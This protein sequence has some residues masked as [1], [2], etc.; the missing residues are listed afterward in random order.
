MRTGVPVNVKKTRP[1]LVVQE[2]EEVA[3]P[4]A[5]GNV[6]AASGDAAA[7]ENLSAFI[8]D[9][10][11]TAVDALPFYQRSLHRII[12]HAR[13]GGTEFYDDFNEHV[14]QRRNVSLNTTTQ[15][16][17]NWTVDNAKRELV[18]NLLDEVARA[19]SGHSDT[20]TLANIQIAVGSR[21][22][23]QR[24]KENTIVFHND[25]A[26]LAE[27]VYS[28]RT[29]ELRFI[30][31]GARINKG[32]AILFYGATDKVGVPN[33]TGCYGEGLKRAITKFIAVGCQV[34]I[35]GCIPERTEDGRGA[36]KIHTYQTWKF[37]ERDGE[38]LFSISAKNPNQRLVGAAHCDRDRFE[39][40]I[41]FPDERYAGSIDL[42]QF[43]VPRAHLRDF[44]Q[45]DAPGNIIFDE[46]VRR[47]VYVRHFYVY[48][49]K[50]AIFS[51]DFN[52]DISRDRDTLEWSQYCDAVAKCWSHL[53]MT[54]ETR[55]NQFYELLCRKFT[56][57]KVELEG[58]LEMA[59]RKK[60][61]ELW[62]SKNPQCFPV[63][64]WRDE[65]IFFAI[66]TTM[67]TNHMYRNITH[68][69]AAITDDKCARVLFLSA[70]VIV[71]KSKHDLIASQ[72]EL[73]ILAQLGP[74]FPQVHCFMSGVTTED[75]AFAW[76][77]DNKTIILNERTYDFRNNPR[78]ALLAVCAKMSLALPLL[79][80][81]AYDP[82][83]F[84]G[85]F[86]RHAVMQA[87]QQWEAEAPLVP[88]SVP[89]PSPPVP[90]VPLL[91]VG[92][93]VTYFFDDEAITATVLTVVTELEEFLLVRCTPAGQPRLNGTSTT[94]VPAANFKGSRDVIIQTLMPPEVP[95]YRLG[96]DIVGERT[97]IWCR[98]RDVVRSYR[99][100]TQPSVPPSVPPPQPSVPSA[101]PS[102]P[103]VP[104]TPEQRRLPVGDGERLER[105]LQSSLSV[106][107]A[108]LFSVTKDGE[109]D[110][111]VDFLL[112]K[113][114]N[115][116]TVIKTGY[117]SLDVP[118]DGRKWK[119]SRW[120][121]TSDKESLKL[122]FWDVRR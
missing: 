66:P 116:K 15:F 14:Q 67:V 25:K 89:S 64:S 38:M 80:E 22:R 81:G 6:A 94:W 41:K 98:N 28:E 102:V 11:L 7:D 49:S 21:T 26:K 31:Y 107:I 54:D 72:R 106:K 77:V 5:V 39:V 112:P 52:M 32:S 122:T 103:L 50:A 42:D 115:S 75:I 8:S 35:E 9:E 93:K 74:M 76:D 69:L 13:N 20:P 46:H 97:D 88:P 51:Y 68:N 45:P 62:K 104:L 84:I 100:D 33:Q 44:G 70:D 4:K 1:H 65:G 40:Y 63:R 111:E 85:G 57:V 56:S 82:S 90:S 23:G 114:P 113:S 43:I 17:S 121:E 24:A 3:P 59:A 118:F 10:N 96:A 30:N 16:V 78:D 110:V 19:N 55:A 29:K 91:S 119:C 105:L 79:L 99:N 109:K 83:A 120:I 48:T 117:V 18:Q 34:R 53:I 101:Q 95:F 12:R 92:Q 86:E 61:C 27:V 71:R 2:E 87:R 37:S 60:I 108:H 47:K 73:G 36:A 58:M